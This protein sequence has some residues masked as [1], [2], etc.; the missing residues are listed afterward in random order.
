MDSQSQ[1][2]SGIALEGLPFRT[3]TK[4]S[5][6]LT[7]PLFCKF[8]QPPLLSLLTMSAFEGTP[9]PLSADVLNGRPLIHS[10]AATCYK[11]FVKCFLRVP[12]AVGPIL[13][14]LCC[15]CKHWHVEISENTSSN[16]QNKLPPQTV[17]I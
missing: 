16:F 14:W 9:F 15:P 17:K 6:F 13:Q 8:M 1:A 11:G 4:F 10:G 12:Q 7:P 2:F 3:S 5:Y